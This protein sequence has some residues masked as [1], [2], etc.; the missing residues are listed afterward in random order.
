M[1]FS[2]KKKKD[3]YKMY[4]LDKKIYGDIGLQAIEDRKNMEAII[5]N[6]QNQNEKDSKDIFD[7]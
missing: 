2:F 5:K 7:F 3:K 6:N 1:Y 4:E